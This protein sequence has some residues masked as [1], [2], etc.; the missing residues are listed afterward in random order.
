MSIFHSSTFVKIFTLNYFI[1]LPQPLYLPF[2][3]AC[4]SSLICLT[5]LIR[6]TQCDI[7]QLYI[8]EYIQII[9]VIFSH[10]QLPL[11]DDFDNNN[12]NDDEHATNAAYDSV[13]FGKAELC[14]NLDQTS[15]GPSHA[16]T[17]TDQLQ[18]QHQDQFIITSL[19]QTGA[20]SPSTT[21]A[22][23]QQQGSGVA[24]TDATPPGSANDD[25]YFLQ[26]LGNKFGKYSAS[27]KST[28]QFHINR[29][30]YKAD[31]GCYEHVD[32]SKLSDTDL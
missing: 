14:E 24:S 21:A 7:F 22:S 17:Y 28:V 23:T 16:L 27:T 26:Y 25:T 5:H 19:S 10:L 11:S 20:T 8:Y 18:Q 12:D 3:L 30:L 32:A 13:Y 1:P 6:Y 9:Y 31:M 2:P 29:I 4:C 15:S